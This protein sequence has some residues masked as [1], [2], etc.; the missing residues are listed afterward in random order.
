MIMNMEDIRCR[1]LQRVAEPNLGSEPLGFSK[2]L[3]CSSERVPRPQHEVPQR[4]EAC[5]TAAEGQFIQ[6]PMMKGP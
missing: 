3:K 4:A 6:N 5:H 1:P 2:H